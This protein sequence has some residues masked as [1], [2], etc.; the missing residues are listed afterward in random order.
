MKTVK[1]DITNIYNSHKESDE[2]SISESSVKEAIR[3]IDSFDIKDIL[4]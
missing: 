4:G 3:Y 1:D 2:L